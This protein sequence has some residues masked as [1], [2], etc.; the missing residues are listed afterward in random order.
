MPLKPKGL[1]SAALQLPAG[2]AGRRGDGRAWAEKAPG[3]CSGPWPCVSG[4]DSRDRTRATL[5]FACP[6]A[7]L[8]GLLVCR[9]FAWARGNEQKVRIDARD[10][11]LEQPLV[12]GRGRR[13]THRPAAGS[14]LLQQERVGV[15]LGQLGSLRS[16]WCAVHGEGAEEKLCETSAAFCLFCQPREQ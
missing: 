13:D 9:V 5:T 11:G 12:Q 15:Q 2:R 4:E 3:S 1:V 8:S 14:Q 16:F 7:R 6:S 10:A